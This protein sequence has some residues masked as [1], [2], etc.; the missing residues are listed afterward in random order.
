MLGINKLT[1]N[2]AAPVT[3]A[4]QADIAFGAG[5][6]ANATVTI[7]VAFVDGSIVTSDRPGFQASK[8]GQL[9]HRYSVNVTLAPGNAGA[10]VAVTSKTSAGFD[11]V[12][13]PASGQTIAASMFDI[14]VVG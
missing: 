5:T 14:V 11:V 4:A 2:Q 8:N 10:S 1:G 7:P 3:L 6:G 13:T 12:L 9:P